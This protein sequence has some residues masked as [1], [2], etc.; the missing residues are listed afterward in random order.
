M[1]LLMSDTVLIDPTLDAAL[2]LLDGLS[3]LAWAA[4][5]P[6]DGPAH[7]GAAPCEGC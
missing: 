1:G 2:R 4:D 5:A 7:E 6:R 3:E